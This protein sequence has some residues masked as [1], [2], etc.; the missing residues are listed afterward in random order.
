MARIAFRLTMPGRGQAVSSSWGQGREYI[1]VRTLTDETAA[2]LMR[3]ES[4]RVWWHRWD[5][6]WVAQVAATRVAPRDRRTRT[7]SF[8]GYDWMIDN[9]LRH[10]D[11]AMPKD[12]VQ[13]ATFDVD[14][15]APRPAKA[16]V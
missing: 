5:D 15:D 2:A 7:T 9:I 8:A 6:G 12:A 11:P 10:G 1:V 13:V 3:G 16:A 4:K 14:L